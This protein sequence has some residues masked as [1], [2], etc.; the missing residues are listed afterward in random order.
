[1]RTV[2]RSAKRSGAFTGAG[3]G[4]PLQPTYV[5]KHARPLAA[6]GRGRHH[7]SQGFT[8]TGE[9]GDGAAVHEVGELA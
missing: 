8:Q 7:D 4:T 1:M 6:Q 9:P 5:L 2:E 3:D